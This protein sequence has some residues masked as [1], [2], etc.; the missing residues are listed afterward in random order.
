MDYRENNQLLADYVNEQYPNGLYASDSAI[1]GYINLL[2]ERGIYEWCSESSAAEIAEE[3]GKH[4][5]YLSRKRVMRSNPLQFIAA[6][7]QMELFILSAM[8][9]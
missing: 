1:R 8:D 9:R 4:R 6:I 7:Y 2:F 5:L 3:K